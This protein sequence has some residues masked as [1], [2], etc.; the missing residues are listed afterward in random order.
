MTIDNALPTVWSA[1]I[2][3]AL[4]DA[5]VFGTPAIV[6]REH[7]GEV[8]EF[9]QTVKVISVGNIAVKTYT[10]DTIIDD[11]DTVSDTEQLL[12]V[13][14]AKY[15]NFAI[16]DID[17]VQSRPKLFDESARTAGWGLIEVSD[18]ALATAMIAGATTVLGTTALTPAGAY[19]RLVDCAVALTGLNTPQEGRFA[20]CPPDFYGLIM[21]DDRFVHS[22]ASGDDVL[23]NGLVGRAAGFDLYQSN[24]VPTGAKVVTGHNMATS[25]V[26]QILKVE[27]YRPQNMFAD[28]LKGLYLYGIKVF[29]GDQLATFPYTIA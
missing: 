28:A 20:V 23:R 2:K 21:K 22:T 8:T 15:F 24:N 11:P 5:H 4:L 19:N 25:F 29:R 14:Q 9:G 7:E 10:K 12:T 3:A 16:D 18:V 17:M 26:E 6:N 13:D 1:R 27:P